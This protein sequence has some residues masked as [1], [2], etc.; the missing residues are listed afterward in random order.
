MKYQLRLVSQDLHG[1]TRELALNAWNAAACL[2]EEPLNPAILRPLERGIHEVLDANVRAYK[3]C[4][5]AS[6]CDASIH[7]VFPRGARD[8]R[9][10]LPDPPQVQRYGLVSQTDGTALLL[11]LL[12][13]SLDVLVQHLPGRR[14]KGLARMLRRQ[15]ERSLQSRLFKSDFCGES[16]LCAVNERVDPWSRQAL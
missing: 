7:P 9:E 6:R 14:L 5:N 3:Y 1:L 11:E 16:P 4:G 10:A 15:F 8:A 2:V 12:R 13:S